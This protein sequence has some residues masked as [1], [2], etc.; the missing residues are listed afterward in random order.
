MTH[1][2]YSPFTLDRFLSEDDSEEAHA[3]GHG[4]EE[5]GRD[6]EGSDP[7]TGRDALAEIHHW[8][9]QCKT[10]RRALQDLAQWLRALGHI[11]PSVGPEYI[12]RHELFGSLTASAE[13]FER[14]LARLQ[15]DEIYHHWGLTTLLIETSREAR[16][17][18]PE[19]SFELARLAQA[20]AAR[21]DEEYYLPEW[22]A[23]LQALAH[24]ELG[25]ALRAMGQ[26]LL[27]ERE[28]HQARRLLDTG[29]GSRAIPHR[30]DQ[31]QARLLSDQERYREAILLLDRTLAE[32]ERMG[33]GELAL[34]W[35]LR[36]WG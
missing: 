30:L 20:A 9:Q 17:R 28:H 10:C 23:D 32:R 12:T 25:D 19:R 3:D 11:K 6:S 31:L 35:V 14:Q 5:Q 18:N 24:G 13:P 21:L 36:R 8:A 2:H 16:H 15:F 29:T 27:A 22:V 33:G 34:P 26:P 7:D 1:V 4:H